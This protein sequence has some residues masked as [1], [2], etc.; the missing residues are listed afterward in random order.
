M[1]IRFRVAEPTT[2]MDIALWPNSFA[3]QRFALSAICFFGDSANRV[4]SASVSY[5]TTLEG[6]SIWLKLHMKRVSLSQY[7]DSKKAVLD[8]IRGDLWRP[9]LNTTESYDIRKNI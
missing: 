8:S 3:N 5:E 1:L 2:S 7:I 4:T 6:T 9:K